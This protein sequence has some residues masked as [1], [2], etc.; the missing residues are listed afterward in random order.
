MTS[1]KIKSLKSSEQLNDEVINY[2]MLLL[3]DRDI[4]RQ[5]EFEK[6]Q[7]MSHYGVIKRRRYTD[8]DSVGSEDSRTTLL[9]TTTSIQISIANK[10]VHYCASKIG[11]Q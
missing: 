11:K 10:Q 7:A 9:Q 4:K 1:I 8:E 6:E 3:K 2:Y 5:E